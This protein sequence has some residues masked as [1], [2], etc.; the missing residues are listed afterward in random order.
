[1]FTQDKIA[2][3]QIA[4]IFGSELLRIQQSARTDS[5]H[6]PQLVKIDPKQILM[7]SS[8][9]HAA[10]QREH[11][12]RI[13]AQ[14]QREA[15]ASHPLPLPTMSQAPVS[16]EPVCE[17]ALQKTVPILNSLPSNS[18]DVLQHIAVSLERIANKI[19]LIEV[20]PKLKAKKKKPLRSLKVN[21]NSI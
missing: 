11:E 20:K 6:E 13:L 14:I 19:D 16:S 3:A 18:V 8:P 9:A 5:G 7:S 21:E 10:S 12:K 17:P 15:E 4:Q 2:T 1:M